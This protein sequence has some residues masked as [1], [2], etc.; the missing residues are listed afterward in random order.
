MELLSINVLF[1]PTTADSDTDDSLLPDDWEKFFWQHGC[2]QRPRQT[3]LGAT[4]TFNSTS[5]VTN[6]GQITLNIQAV[7][8]A[9]FA[10]GKT[11]IIELPSGNYALRVFFR[12]LRL[13]L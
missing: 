13:L 2:Y 10:P 6:H 11:T 9:T 5:L 7:P 12:H 1:V 8:I 4:A 3:R